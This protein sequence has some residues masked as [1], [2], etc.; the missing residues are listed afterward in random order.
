MGCA[1][2]C[3]GAGVGEWGGARATAPAIGLH[4]PRPAAVRR[5]RYLG[6]RKLAFGAPGSKRWPMAR[7]EGA[8]PC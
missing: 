3:S 5:G 7:A 8:S 2:A 6:P 4:I 1:M